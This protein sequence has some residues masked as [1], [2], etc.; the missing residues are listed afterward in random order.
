[1]KLFE[2]NMKLVYWWVARKYKHCGDKEDL[3]QEGFMGLW[4]AIKTFNESK[5]LKFSTYAIICIDNQIK[6]FLRNKKKFVNFSDTD[7]IDNYNFTE[8][9]FDFSKIEYDILVKKLSSSQKYILQKLYQGITQQEIADE[10]GV[11]QATIGRKFKQIKE[12]INSDN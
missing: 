1:M 3:T 6:M 12:I 2:E 11:S 10:L 4:K 5:H 7:Y 8:N 9:K